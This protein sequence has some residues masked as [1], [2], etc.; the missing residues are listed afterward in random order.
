MR[1]GLTLMELLT[2]VSILATLAALLYPV[3]LK[4]RSEEVV[5][6]VKKALDEFF[7]QKRQ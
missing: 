7:G 6:E 4:V 2:V 3:Y 1:K 5:A